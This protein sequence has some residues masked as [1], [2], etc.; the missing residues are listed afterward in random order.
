M[1]IDRAILSEYLVQT[2]RGP[3][4]ANVGPMLEFLLDQDE[5]A[6]QG[7]ID[8]WTAERKTSLELEKV[9]LDARSAEI[10][11]ILAKIP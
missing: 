4:R 6:Q 10:R 11:S 7:Q 8:A 3:L 9:Q 2:F 5:R 1:A